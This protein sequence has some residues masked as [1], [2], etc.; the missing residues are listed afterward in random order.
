M[1]PRHYLSCYGPQFVRGLGYLAMR[2]DMRV[3]RFAASLWPIPN[4]ATL[5]ESRRS[6]VS[7]V[8]TTSVWVVIAGAW[9]AM[10]TLL[11]V[12]QI[13]ILQWLI[14]A[15]LL[16]LV[17]PFGLMFVALVVVSVVGSNS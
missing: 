6:E 1:N 17:A 5:A 3:Y 12:V 11:F 2:A 10:A 4:Y 9:V 15:L 7:Q 14:F 8:V 16:S 13:P